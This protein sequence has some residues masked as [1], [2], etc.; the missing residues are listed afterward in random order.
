[1][2]LPGPKR[3]QRPTAGIG[4]YRVR[5]MPLLICNRCTSDTNHCNTPQPRSDRCSGK[6]HVLVV[7]VPSEVLEE[8]G[9]IL[10]GGAIWKYNFNL[11]LKKKRVWVLSGNSVLVANKEILL[12]ERAASL[13]AQSTNSDARRRERRFPLP[14]LR[15]RHPLFRFG[16]SG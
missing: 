3:R 16:R 6:R 5:A 13:N 2:L 12:E 11:I 10:T 4:C 1:M 14:R 9:P 8:L 15:R 7:I